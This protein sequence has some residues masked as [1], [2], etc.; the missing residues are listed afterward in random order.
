MDGLLIVGRSGKPIVLSRFRHSRSVYPLLHADYLRDLVATIQA[1]PEAKPLGEVAGVV[2]SDRDLPPILPVPHA[3]AASK[4]NASEE[5]DSDTSEAPSLPDE[6]NEWSDA[7]R[8]RSPEEQV[9]ELEGGSVL[10][11]IKVGELRFLCPVS[12]ESTLHVLT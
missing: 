11:H 2:A 3:D 6:A 1:N 10:C 4:D 12:R 5:H 8:A 7:A 9:V